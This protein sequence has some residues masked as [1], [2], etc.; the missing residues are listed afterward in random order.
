MCVCVWALKNTQFG[1]THMWVHVLAKFTFDKNKRFEPPFMYVVN[2]NAYAELL[3]L[4]IHGAPPN[5][6]FSLFMPKADI[7]TWGT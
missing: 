1:Y 3:A 7:R 2:G 6:A 4:H 5:R